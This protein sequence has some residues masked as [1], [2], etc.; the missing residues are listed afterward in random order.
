MGN[1]SENFTWKEFEC[2]GKKCCGHK[3]YV[4]H[5]LLGGLEELRAALR[6]KYKGRDIKL[7]VNSGYRCVKHN[8]EVG[9]NPNSFH[10]QGMAADVVPVGC[11][12][13]E[14]VDQAESMRVFS[15]GGIGIYDT[16]VH[17]DTRYNGPAR[18]EKKGQ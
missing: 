8:E 12:I 14:L 16:F 1:I 2:H 7:V 5:R 9:G 3:C 4:E 17:L 6:R 11:T 13:K 15:E 18:W 10:L